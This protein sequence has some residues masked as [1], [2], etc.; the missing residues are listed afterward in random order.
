MLKISFLISF[1]SVL[2][3]ATCSLDDYIDILDEDIHNNEYVISTITKVYDK[4]EIDKIL[5]K[6][7]T[8]NE[9]VDKNVEII[10]DE[11]DKLFKIKEELSQNKTI[12]FVISNI[13][14]KKLE[15]EDA[16]SNMTNRLDTIGY[17][18]L[19][20]T[21]LEDIN[22][23][24]ESEES[25]T[26]KS[27]DNI[28]PVAVENLSNRATQ[29]I[30]KLNSTDTLNKIKNNSSTG[31]E[32]I[33]EIQRELFNEQN[34]FLYLAK[35]KVYPTKKIDK[36]SVNGEN[37]ISSIK[38]YELKIGSNME[39]LPEE[40]RQ[41]IF[42]YIQKESSTIQKNNSESDLKYKIVLDEYNSAFSK[43]SDQLSLLTTQLND[44][45]NSLNKIFDEISFDCNGTINKCIDNAQIEIEKKIVNLEK[46]RVYEKSQELKYDTSG[47]KT[48]DDP[49][50]DIA[51]KAIEQANK[52]VLKHKDITPLS[53][54][55]D[56]KNKDALFGFRD[57]DR[58]YIFP[59]SGKGDEFNITTIVKFKLVKEEVVRVIDK[60]G[61]IYKE[62]K[63]PYTSRV[64]LDRNLGAKKPCDNFYDIECFGD[65]YQW[66]RGA[67]GHQ[68]RNSPIKT[69]YSKSTTPKHGDFIKTKISNSDNWIDKNHK[70][71]DTN[72]WLDT[73]N[74]GLNNPCPKGYRVPT[75]K[76]LEDETISL[77]KESKEVN[78]KEKLRLPLSGY[79]HCGT[80]DIRYK[81][82]FGDLWS[83]STT[84]Q[85]ASY[86]EFD[87][88]FNTKTKNEDGFK[89]TGMAVRCIKN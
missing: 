54:L 64:W 61:N 73:N 51:K 45:N 6:V 2:A 42:E 72:F 58:F 29:T 74:G 83:S 79:R 40:F 33:K 56:E 50:V 63:S 18:G 89:G 7:D 85:T 59:M 47:V 25:L 5:N 13:N 30:K 19:F 77:S 86:L 60:E 28:T 39:K 67:D 75:I 57:L 48:D 66:G 76:E 38:A 8:C 34:S 53:K 68:K 10:D 82:E 24:I 15:L 23:F 22:P 21:T 37:N 26:K 35:I 44:M 17:E 12:K 55:I 78:I 81:K 32:I 27:M 20:F 16:K 80:G 88:E 49:K 14:A 84:G 69:I 65:Y 9:Q 43:K 31:I 70:T 4:N 41:N 62:I 87:E 3:L 71:D 36:L 1:I 11:I 52:I 46:N